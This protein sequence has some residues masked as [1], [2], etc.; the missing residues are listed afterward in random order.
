MCLRLIAET[1][2]RSA[3][4]SH[5]SCKVL[6][7]YRINKMLFKYFYAFSLITLNNLLFAADVPLFFDSGMSFKARNG[8]NSGRRFPAE[9][10]PEDLQVPGPAERAVGAHSTRSP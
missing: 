8:A 5:P 7:R 6:R 1:D 9:S 3:G 4:D 10:C 2:A